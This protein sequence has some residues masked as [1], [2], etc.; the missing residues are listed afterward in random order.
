MRNKLAKIVY[1]L[2]HPCVDCGEY[3]PL[4]LEFDHYQKKQRS[5]SS[6]IRSRAS[7]ETIQEEI[8][9]CKVRCANC[10][11]RKTLLKLGWPD[12]LGKGA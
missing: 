3:D 4:V 5:I 7:W 8:A 12:Y 10:H 1:L 2:D 9:K 6:M 11:R